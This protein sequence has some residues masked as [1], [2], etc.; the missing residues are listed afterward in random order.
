M[1]KYYSER[2]SYEYFF[3]DRRALAEDLTT[4]IKTL[5]N[6]APRR[7]ILQCTRTIGRVQ[8]LKS[9]FESKHIFLLRNPWDQWYSYKVDKY[10]SSTPQIIVSQSDTPEV[11]TDVASHRG[12]LPLQGTNVNEK[13]AFAYT[14]PLPPESDYAL[15]FAVWAYSFVLSKR[16]CDVIVDMDSI[17][18]DPAYRG[19]ALQALAE[20]GL[21]GIDLSDA[22]LPTAMFEPREQRFYELVED[23]VLEVFRNHD[24]KAEEIGE[25]RS[26]I[27]GRRTASFCGAG[28][29]NEAARIRDVL[30]A[31]DRHIASVTAG[32]TEAVRIRDGEIAEAALDIRSTR[33]E[34]ESLRAQIGDTLDKYQKSVEDVQVYSDLYNSKAMEL[35]AAQ[36][37]LDR[38]SVFESALASQGEELA[39]AHNAV[40]RLEEERTRYESLVRELSSLRDE[41]DVQHKTLAADHDA[42]SKELAN[43][44]DEQSRLE[45]ALSQSENAL[46]QSRQQSSAQDRLERLLQQ[47]LAAANQVVEIYQNRV[48]TEIERDIRRQRG[49]A[50]RMLGLVRGGRPDRFGRMDADA[51]KIEAFLDQFSDAQLGVPRNGR[52]QRIL[53]YLAGVT[54]VVDDFPIFDRGIYELLYPDVA[55]SKL[56]AF[57][58]F[59]D[60]GR[61]EGRI[62]HPIIDRDYYVNQYPEVGVLDMSAAEHFVRFG[63]DKGYNPCAL[64]DVKWYHE[65]YPDV[66]VSGCNPVLHF[67]RH[68]RCAPHPLFDA[69]HYLWIYPDVAASKLNPLTHYLIY[70]AG[71]GRNPSPWFDSRFYMKHNPDLPSNMNPLSHYVVAGHKEGRRPNSDFNPARYIEIAGDLGGRNVLEHYI[72]VGRLAE[73][74]APISSSRRVG[75]SVPNL[76]VT[77]L[78][79]S[80]NAPDAARRKIVLMVNTFYPHPDE[81]AGSMEQVSFARIFQ[82]LGYEVAYVGLLDF[83]TKDRY[84]DDLEAM[85]VHCVSSDHYSNLE[86]YLFLNAELLEIA[87]MSRVH[88]GG[89]WIDRVRLFCPNAKVIFNTVDLHYIR[90]ERQ[91]ALTGDAAGLAEAQKTKEAEFKCIRSADLTIVLSTTEL[92]ILN[93]EI[94]GAAVTIVPIMREIGEYDF[95]DFSERRDIA[96]IGGFQHQPNVDAVEYFLSEVWPL[97]LRNLPDLRIRIIGSHLPEALSSRP[98]RNVE[99]VGYVPEIDPELDRLKLT[100]APLRYGAG[101]K[102]K[103][104]SSLARGVPCV[105]SPI[106][107]EGMGFEDGL[108]I[109]V[110]KT[111]AEF[112]NAIT[113]LYENPAQWD[114]LSREGFALIQR[115]YSLDTGARIVKE[116]LAQN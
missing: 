75:V 69:D 17:C 24:F 13:L 8:W 89:A 45:T 33:E 37:E 14:H 41:A 92:D 42:L 12:V 84:R 111:P 46:L 57:V 110:G 38:L 49:V 82:S 30:L 19:A 114:R 47:D 56:D 43:A 20:V 86:E 77:T 34:V 5:I 26:Y 61:R 97:V 68:P 78:T 81:D 53:R 44:K 6:A 109:V 99:W 67:L 55:S 29:A 74:S 27:D 79:A 2:L 51:R 54:S 88:W 66:K 73:Q 87:F 36:G 48:A 80:A 96:F 105:A 95:A 103:V 64:F 91:A 106:A 23:Q 52:R 108:N 22:D 62:V 100:V 7:P 65:R 102:G 11:L 31:G 112:A 72:Y 9:N 21:E 16:H 107:A 70:G 32:L 59:I 50:G 98:D 4:Y 28:S 115:D 10:I 113:R 58:H 40:S 39:K 3:L 63:A 104:V 116:L 85:G 18:S 15:F 25:I 60:F 35:A 90:E 94:P 83:A 93:K 1:K 71:E 76:E 101:A